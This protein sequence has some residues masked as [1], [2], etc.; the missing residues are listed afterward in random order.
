MST[1]HDPA[2]HDVESTTEPAKPRTSRAVALF[3]LGGLLLGLMVSWLAL[4]SVFSGLLS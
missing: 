2:E 1:E 3:V 4:A